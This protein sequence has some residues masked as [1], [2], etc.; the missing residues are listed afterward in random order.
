MLLPLLL[1]GQFLA[2]CRFATSAIS[3]Y[4]SLGNLSDESHHATIPPVISPVN[5]NRLEAVIQGR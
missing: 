2:T 5:H 1:P 4:V 3:Y